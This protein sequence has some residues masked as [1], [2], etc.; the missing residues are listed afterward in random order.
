MPPDVYVVLY[1]YL[2]AH[3]TGCSEETLVVNGTFIYKTH[4]HHL[5]YN[6]NFHDTKLQ[7]LCTKLRKLRCPLLVCTR[8]IA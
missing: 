7:L 2:K 8:Y 1:S 3:V 4:A 6:N 5:V